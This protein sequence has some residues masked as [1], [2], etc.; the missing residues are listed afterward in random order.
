M[1]YKNVVK[2]LDEVDPLVRLALIPLSNSRI[3][4]IFGDWGCEAK[5]FY[6][7]VLKEPD[8][9]NPAALLGNVVHQVLENLIEN[10]VKLSLEDLH[11]EYKKQLKIYDPDHWINSD[12]RDAGSIMID[13]FFEAN[14]DEK[15]VSQEKVETTSD[16]YIIGK[17]LGFEIAIG[18]A[19]IRG[20]I[21]RIDYLG[22]TI[23][24]TDY[25][26]GK[27]EYPAKHIHKNLQLGIYALA[28]K[29]MYP[30]KQ[31]YASLYYLRSGRKKGHLFTDD[32]L[33]TVAK[34]IIDITN[35]LCDIKQFKTTS[36]KRICRYCPHAASG[37]CS[38]G[39]RVLNY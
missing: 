2:Y 31:I 21:D 33:N 13:D 35:K 11:V 9:G 22:D 30:D 23:E 36:N 32:D 38:T 26:T 6:N 8:P 37:I 4:T 25:K 3:E 39:K 14:K 20:F 19:H 16:K 7:Y 29:K 12:L 27:N 28:A 1:N 18:L 17:E 24:I 15:F 5:Y 34:N 10:D